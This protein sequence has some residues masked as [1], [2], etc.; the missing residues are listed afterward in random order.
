MA[1]VMMPATEIQEDRWPSTVA[2]QR[3]LIITAGCSQALFLGE[4]VVV[5]LE[6]TEF[7]LECRICPC[8]T[9]LQCHTYLAPVNCLN[10]KMTCLGNFIALHINWT[11]IK[12]KPCDVDLKL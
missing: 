9:G 12:T 10:V 7:I 3:G 8:V 2:F 6:N 4:T 5:K 1:L 11:Y